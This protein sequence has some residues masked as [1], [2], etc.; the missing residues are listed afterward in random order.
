MNRIANAIPWWS[1]SGII[2]ND[3]TYAY[4]SRPINHPMLYSFYSTSVRMVFWI[5][6]LTIDSTKMSDNKTSEQETLEGR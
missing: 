1:D 3:I 5:V 4:A 2:L 6:G